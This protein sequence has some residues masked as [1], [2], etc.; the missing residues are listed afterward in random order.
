MAYDLENAHEVQYIRGNLDLLPEVYNEACREA[1]IAKAK[2]AAVQ[3]MVREDIRQT[4]S[5]Y[6]AYASNG[7]IEKAIE[8][9]NK[10]NGMRNILRTVEA[11]ARKLEIPP[12]IVD[13]VVQKVRNEAVKVRVQVQLAQPPKLLNQRFAATV[14]DSW[15]ISKAFPEEKEAVKLMFVYEKKV[16]AWFSELNDWSTQRE[17]TDLMGYVSRGKAIMDKHV[18]LIEEANKITEV[19]N[20]GNRKYTENPPYIV[21]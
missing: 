7:E 8:T 1:Y 10:L 3:R 21:R 20:E 2:N 9:E 11:Q 12:E 15:A 5:T 18:A 17:V 14:R 4:E 6:F 19:V 16:G 13:E